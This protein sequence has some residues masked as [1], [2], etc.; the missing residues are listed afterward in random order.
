MKRQPREH[1][2]GRVDCAR[3]NDREG[4]G[5]QARERT[6][7]EAR[8]A[9]E[10]RMRWREK[11]RTETNH[12]AACRGGAGT[13]ERDRNQAPRLPL[14]EQQLDGERHRRDG[15]G[16]RRGHAARR[17]G[18]EERLPFGARQLQ[19][20][21]DHRAEGA[22]GHDDRTFGTERA[23]APDGDGG[24]E[25][26]QE[27]DP[28]PHAA[29]ADQDGLDRFGDPVATD[30]LGAVPRHQAH[31]QR[32]GGG[33][34]HDELAEVVA[35]RRDQRD[36]PALEEEQVG[37][38]PD[39]AQEG[40]RDAR[41]EEPDRDRGD[42]HRDDQ[43][44]GREIAELAGARGSELPDRTGRAHRPRTARPGRSPVSAASERRRAGA[45]ARS[46]ARWA[47]ESRGSTRSPRGVSRTTTCRR[48]VVPGR[49]RTRFRAAIRSISPTMVWC[50][51]CKRS[52]RTPI[53]AAVPS[54]MPL[55]ASST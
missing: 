55:N 17:A 53:V 27:R 30:P 45:T 38:E 11:E 50:R 40:P 19:E 1:V 8:R 34:Q 37:E 39:E 22:A 24:R 49:R 42:R 33:H 35:R 9:D 36:T 23:A 48:S 20:L 16:E 31:D 51:S 5:R 18:H 7:D 15:R 14:E 2:L 32:A 28:R 46:S 47:S 29:A 4:A 6:P 44:R 12:V 3:E 52:A 10:E 41:A 21:R 26:L 25:R 13:G 54:G 43:P